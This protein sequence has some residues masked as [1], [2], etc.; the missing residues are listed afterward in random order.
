MMV[1]ATPKQQ[2]LG[3]QAPTQ[4]PES[5]HPVNIFLYYQ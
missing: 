4:V 2:A 1:A 5:E 3:F